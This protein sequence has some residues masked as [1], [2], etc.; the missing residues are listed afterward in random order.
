MRAL[1]SSSCRPGLRG[2]A[3]RLRVGN[4]VT[5]RDVLFTAPVRAHT[6]G[7]GALS[8]GVQPPSCGVACLTTHS[9]PALSLRM[10]TAIP[11]LPLRDCV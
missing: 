3:G 1:E 7:T 2:R 5:A 6:V 10:S 4:P 11:V 9:H 8:R